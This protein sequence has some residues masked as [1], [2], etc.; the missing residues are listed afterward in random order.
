LFQSS[1]LGGVG[2]GGDFVRLQIGVIGC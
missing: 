1:D 2:K